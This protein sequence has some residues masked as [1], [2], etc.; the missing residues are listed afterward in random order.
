MSH[1]QSSEFSTC[2]SL[3]LLTYHSTPEYKVLEVAGLTT[4]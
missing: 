4:Y 3:G 2:V 1:L